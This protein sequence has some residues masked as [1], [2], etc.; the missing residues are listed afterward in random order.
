MDNIREAYEAVLKKLLSLRDEDTGA[1][2]GEL[3]SSALS[4]ALAVTALATDNDTD[5]AQSSVGLAWL[6]AHANADGGWGDTPASVS[7]LATTL[8]VCATL[9]SAQKQGIP[10]LGNAADV[11][12]I[13]G[14]K[15]IE[16]RIGRPCP[17]TVV[18]ALGRVYGVDRTFAAP[19]LAYL[20]MCGEDTRAWLSVPPLPFLLA[21]MPQGIYRFLR[22]QVVSYALPAL[23]AV[24]LCRHVCVC[25]T[26]R[27]PAWGRLFAGALLKRLVALQPKHGGFLDAIPLTA[28]VV[29]ALR[30]AGYGDHPVSQRGVSF[31]RQAVR[32]NGSWA[33]DSNLRIWVTSLAVRAVWKA[34]ERGQSAEETKRMAEWL[35]QAQ[36][37]EKH[38]FTGA[39]PGGWAWTDLP[40]GVPDADDTC[41]ALLALKRLKESGCRVDATASVCAGLHWLRM[42][43][44]TDGG[45]PTFSRGWG[46]LPFDRS[47]PDIS[48]HALSAWVSWCETT[49]SGQLPIQRLMQYLKKTQ[50]RDGAWTPLWFGHQGRADGKNPVVGTAR[51]VDA[52]RT[53][54]GLM[55][56]QIMLF[57]KYNT[58]LTSMLERGEAWLLE[59]QHEDGG[60]S[61]GAQSTVEETALAVIAL[62]GGGGACNSAVRCGCA[63]LAENWRAG[64]ERP[65]P[66]GLYFSSLWYHERLYPLIWTL[67]ALGCNRMGSC[68]VR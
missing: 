1:W 29:L 62:T 54:V 56:K 11:V 64:C 24:G 30:H 2:T 20:A 43:Q 8:I 33:I 14:E 16:S 46:R 66:I 10:G 22:L 25:N 5:V 27:R 49:G 28:F 51:V 35:I 4:T 9:R 7:N 23:I 26:S 21:L 41:G 68:Q 19:I 61:A 31:L 12:L 44:N 40:G 47:C 3:A 52:L 38:P 45:M 53:V 48:A 67:E 17:E 65:V 39:I 15:W 50:E 59:Q 32:S 63:W 58:M 6:I 55:Q 36:S 57:G 13:G 37:K 18:R 42:L 60:W 34:D